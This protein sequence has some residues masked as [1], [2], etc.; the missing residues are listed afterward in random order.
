MVQSTRGRPPLP[1]GMPPSGTGATASSFL[2]TQKGGTPRR[3]PHQV[4]LTTTMGESNL[5]SPRGN[6][7]LTTPSEH[8][9]TTPGTD[10]TP[11]RVPTRSTESPKQK[12]ER[13]NEVDRKIR[14]ELSEVDATVIMDQWTTRLIRTKEARHRTGYTNSN[15]GWTKYSSAYLRN[16]AVPK[17]GKRGNQPVISEHLR[18]KVDLEAAKVTMDAA[19]F[20]F[21][22]FKAWIE[23]FVRESVGSR[24]NAPVDWRTCPLDDF[25]YKLETYQKLYREIFPHVIQEGDRAMIARIAIRNDLL[26]YL[27]HFACTYAAQ[28]GTDCKLFPHSED[29][30]VNTKSKVANIDTFSVIAEGFN[31]ER[32]KGRTT[33]IA[34]KA[35]AKKG[36]ALKVLHDGNALKIGAFNQEQDKDLKKWAKEMK[37][38]AKT[39]DMTGHE[40]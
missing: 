3:R 4:N 40:S 1:R 20:D 39:Q 31:W 15:S 27:S 38:R 11:Q 34:F 35:A 36:D 30:T 29:K 19:G 25:G 23:P 16:S 21:K 37:R 18:K 14:S 26:A 12:N 6:S 5:A 28:M 13:L 17:L 33:E 22:D 7:A 32:I 8:V 2:T 9:L 24:P 10:H